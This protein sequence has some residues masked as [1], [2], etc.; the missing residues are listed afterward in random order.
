[1]RNE[2]TSQQVRTSY[3]PPRVTEVG[4]FAEITRGQYTS[5]HADDSDHGGYWSQPV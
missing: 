4:D 3:E 5:E 1:M 2:S